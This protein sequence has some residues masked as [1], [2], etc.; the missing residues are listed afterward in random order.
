MCL[1]YQEKSPRG[2]RL[3]LTLLIHMLRGIGLRNKSERQSSGEPAAGGHPSFGTPSASRTDEWA[4]TS[5]GPETE[6]VVLAIYDDR[7]YVDLVRVL[8]E[9]AGF[10][11]LTSTSAIKGLEILR[12]NPQD[13]GVLLLD[14]NMPVMNGADMLQYVRKLNPRV[15]VIGL[16]GVN[17]SGLPQAFSEGVDSLFSKPFKVPELVSAIRALAAR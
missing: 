2:I 7:H 10:K 4:G 8:L 6:I 12:H 3:A 14:F 15:K 17:A 9:G 5:G 13:F 16:T 11:I 1:G